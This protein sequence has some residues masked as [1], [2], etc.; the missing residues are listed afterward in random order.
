M[1]YTGSE[2]QVFV[3]VNLLLNL[4][5]L[6]DRGSLFGVG[7]LPLFRHLPFVH[8]IGVLLVFL[9]HLDIESLHGRK[10]T[11]KLSVTKTFLSKFA[12]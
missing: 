7:L 2:I 11:D 9:H 4:L 10:L 6:V 8:E 5:W 1:N 12:H 3:E